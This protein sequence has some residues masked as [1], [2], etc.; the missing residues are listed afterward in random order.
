[1]TEENNKKEGFFKKVL[2]SIK[3]FE[4]YILFAGEKTR[5]VMGYFFMLIIIFA[6]IVSLVFTYKFNDTIKRTKDYF[7]NNISTLNYMDGILDI[8]TKDSIINENANEIIQIV[9][10]D[11]KAS[12]EN[13]K[14][15]INKVLNYDSG[16]IILKDR[17]ILKNS[18]ITNITDIIEYKYS[19]IAKNYNIDNFNKEQIVEYINNTNIFGLYFGFFIVAVVYLGVIYSISSLLDVLLLSILAFLISRLVRIKIRFKACFNMSIHAL[20]LPILLNCIYILI[21]NLTGF[22]IQYFNW[23]YTTISYIY[24][25]VAILIIKTD[26]INKQMELLKIIEEQ[27][28]VRNEMNQ[29]EQQPKEKEQEKDEKE[30]TK[31]PKDNKEDKNVPDEPEGSN[32]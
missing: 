12:E 20:T 2:L 6:I 17:I 13:E 31:K 27:E 11:T 29:Q 7:V 32:A 30:N 23:M 15:Y 21:N 9:I 26:T 4:A 25:I 19:E 16:L 18:A 5:N 24:I 14:E 1:M 28:K 8:D 22:T 3:D 10:I